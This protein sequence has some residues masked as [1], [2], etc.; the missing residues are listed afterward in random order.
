[1]VRRR[2]D[3]GWRES[4]LI[5]GA[6]IV[7]LFVATGVRWS[8][9]NDISSNPLSLPAPLAVGAKP[10]P[11]FER[12]A[13]ARVSDE[14]FHSSSIRHCARVVAL[15]LDSGKKRWTS[16]VFGLG[17]AEMAAVAGTVLVDIGEGDEDEPAQRVIAVDAATGSVRWK[18]YHLGPVHIAGDLA[19]VW[20]P[21]DG[22]KAVDVRSGEP[23]WRHDG[24]VY[25][26]TQDIAVVDVASGGRTGVVGVDSRTGRERWTLAIDR[27][28]TFATIDG[29]P[30]YA[31]GDRIRPLDLLNG[32]LG[33]EGFL[34][35]SSQAVWLPA[36]M[37]IDG[38]VVATGDRLVFASDGGSGSEIWRRDGSVIAEVDGDVIIVRHVRTSST[39]EQLGELERVDVATGST[40]W[41]RS[42]RGQLRSATSLLLAFRTADPGALIIDPD[43]GADLAWVA[44]ET[45][46]VTGDETATWLAQ[47]RSLRMLDANAKTVWMADLPGPALAVEHDGRTAYVL[48]DAR[49]ER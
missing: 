43:S 4:R 31:D 48:A 19:L 1:M 46:L 11:P 28:K 44:G 33:D 40:R 25:S 36:P 45:E 2:S 3:R 6:I 18:D 20:W 23:V 15:D 47:G 5:P 17:T 29:A 37:V 21:E 12:D 39:A 30:A 24:Y 7:A 10:P 32:T 49:A 38:V 13:C 22:T 34:Y 16:A 8:H 14:R 9:S 26:T 35:N 42:F 27:T 41:R